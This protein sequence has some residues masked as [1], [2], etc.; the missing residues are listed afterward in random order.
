M[1]KGYQWLLEHK[2]ANSI[3]KINNRY[4][5]LS[6]AVKTSQP[7]PK[8][9]SLAKEFIRMQRTCEYEDFDA[10][11]KMKN[12][13]Y[14]LVFSENESLFRCSCPYGL[15][16]IFCKHSIGIMIK[17]G[18]LEIPDAAMAVPLHEHRQR[19]RPKANKGWWSY[20]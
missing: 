12:S 14:E 5:V 4:Y 18:G 10:W 20:E 15:K 8:L 3:I 17:F 6:S 16:W 13:V 19:G 1:T 11:A 9:S 2:A 7:A